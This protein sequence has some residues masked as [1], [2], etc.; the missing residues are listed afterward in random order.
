MM[1]FFGFYGLFIIYYLLFIIYYY[2]LQFLYSS[3]FLRVVHFSLPPA[4]LPLSCFPPSPFSFIYIISRSIILLC[5]VCWGGTYNYIQEKERKE[6]KRKKKNEKNN[7]NNTPNT[8]TTINTNQTE[9]KNKNVAN[10]LKKSDNH[11][12]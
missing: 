8:T 3:H 7:H 2:F 12:N 10:S 1:N 5:N 4:I 6:K 9:T 11:I